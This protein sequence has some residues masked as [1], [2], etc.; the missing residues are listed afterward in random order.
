[1]YTSERSTRLSNRPPAASTSPGWAIRYCTRPVRGALSRLSSMSACSRA[2]LARAASTADCAST[3]C[4]RVAA[5]PASA[6][7]TWDL[8]AASAAWALCST[9]RSSSSCCWARA[10][11]LTRVSVRAKRLLAAVSSAWRWLTT[12]AAVCFSLSRWA[13]IARAVSWA[14]S[15]WRTCASAWVSWASST[16]VSIF[17]TTWPT[18]TKSP[19]STRIS[20]TRPGSLVATSTSVA[21]MRPLPPAKPAGRPLGFSVCQ[22]RAAIPARTRT[23]TPRPSHLRAFRFMLASLL[24]ILAPNCREWTGMGC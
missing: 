15:A 23:T 13:T 16:W 3:T 21:S 6:E 2:T 11:R 17:A 5:M 10:L 20:A 18:L 24:C 22:A 19:S 14:F 12:A 8:A 9:A 4:E 1:M 7:T